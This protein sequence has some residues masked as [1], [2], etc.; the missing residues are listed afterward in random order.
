[1]SHATGRIQIRFYGELGDFL[2][3]RHRQRTIAVVITG[4]PTVR[5]VAQSLGVPHPE[6]GL[7]TVDGN[8]TGFDQS[9]HHGMRIAVY[10]AFHSLDL[11]GAMPL[12][13]PLGEE[14]RFVLD[15]HLGQLASKLRLLGFDVLYRND[16]EDDELA[17]SSATEH[18][19]L[20][21]RD[22]ALLMRR[23]VVHG[24]WVRSTHPEKQVIE[25]VERFDLA[26]SFR[27]FSRCMRCNSLV[28]PAPTEEVA[29][30][31]PQRVRDR[32]S[33]FLRCEGCGR[34]YWEGTHHAALERWV[35]Q[36]RARWPL[37]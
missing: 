33:A 17:R 37:S 10:P 36:M 32:H 19:V 24:H 8:P 4:H 27:P 13:P 18:R 2:P 25:I 3:K 26:R 16:L 21:T 15:V 9:V 1:V 14:V 29:D 35:A 31:V 34:V 5:E 7:L 30:R 11:G 12:R 22:Q 28:R 20:L 23:M 6:I